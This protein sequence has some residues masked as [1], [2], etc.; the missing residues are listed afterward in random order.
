MLEHSET[1]QSYSNYVEAAVFDVDKLCESIE[2]VK[3]EYRFQIIPIQN[4]SKAPAV[5]KWQAKDI[6][7]DKIGEYFDPDETLRPFQ[8]YGIVIPKNMVVIDVD[9]K[10]GKDGFASQLKLEKDL[11]ISLD[12]STSLIVSSGSG[13]YSKHYFFTLPEDHS[14]VL[15]D[16]LKDAGYPDIDIK[17]HGG[18]VIGA[19]SNYAE[20][21]ANS[22]SKF[23]GNAYSFIQQGEPSEIP[24][25]LLSSITRP[26][27]IKTTLKPN[28]SKSLNSSG[29]KHIAEH[30]L[31][32]ISADC[33]YELWLKVGMALHFET[34]GAQEGYELFDSWSASVGS[35]VGEKETFAKWG[36]FQ[37]APDVPCTLGTI[38][39]YAKKHPDFQHPKC[40]DYRTETTQ[41]NQYIIK[42]LL[43]GKIP[44]SAITHIE[45]FFP[46]MIEDEESEDAVIRTSEQLLKEASPAFID[47]LCQSDYFKHPLVFDG[48]HLVCSQYGT[49]FYLNHKGL[50]AG[51]NALE[52]PYPSTFYSREDTQKKILNVIQEALQQPLPLY[53]SIE[54]SFNFPKLIVLKVTQGSGKTDSTLKA[55]AKLPDNQ[56]VLLVEPTTRKVD[57]AIHDLRETYGKVARPAY[58]PSK[59]NNLCT[60]LEKSDSKILSEN[61]IFDKSLCNSC[62]YMDECE[63]QKRKSINSN[64]IISTTAALVTG[65]ES[66]KNQLGEKPEIDHL[67]IDEDPVSIMIKEHQ[68]DENSISELEQAL[69]GGYS[70]IIKTIRDIYSSFKDNCENK[71]VIDMSASISMI[72][73]IAKD[74]K[75]YCE[76]EQCINDLERARD[77]IKFPEIENLDDDWA[78]KII[79]RNHLSKWYSPLNLLFSYIKT[80]YQEGA[81]SRELQKLSNV[82]VLFMPKVSE[83]GTDCLTISEFREDYLGVAKKPSNILL[84]DAT[85]NQSIIEKAFSNYNYD[86]KVIEIN[87]ARN[88]KTIQQGS[89]KNG[90]RELVKPKQQV[91]AKA[92]N[93]KGGAVI[94]RKSLS[95]TF[96]GSYF[97]SLKGRNT[98]QG[99]NGEEIRFSDCQYFYEFGQFM[100]HGNGIASKASA[101]WAD[102]I[103]H[104]DGSIVD[105]DH[106]LRFETEMVAVPYC[107]PDG[108]P[109]GIGAMRYCYYDSRLH[110]VDI[111]KTD[112]EHIQA[113]RTRSV[114]S[115]KEKALYIDS[116]QPIFGRIV[117]EVYPRDEF[118]KVVANH[119]GIELEKTKP[120]D[121][122]DDKVREL[123]NFLEDGNEIKASMGEI[124]KNLNTT[125]HY[126]K[127]VLSHLKNCEQE[128][129]PLYRL[130]KSRKKGKG[131]KL[132]YSLIN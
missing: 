94:T 21:R 28:Y 130:L 84:L 61:S 76:I 68:I 39:F 96:S 118:K 114:W 6:P 36:S 100:Y 93:D 72:E 110:E 50:L 7:M 77:E 71:P 113:D 108:N 107:M 116:S 63:Y 8:A 13:G 119:L 29:V 78:N 48:T 51:C 132:H 70:S 1:Q 60:K 127:T 30:Y 79:K 22:T 10:I 104:V 126:A 19:G 69:D 85:A 32:Y 65:G 2:F 91:L 45:F 109:K 66:L 23:N 128:G 34:G 117:D 35:Y 120:E 90:K 88:L 49:N 111:S 125:E 41:F 95:S 105:Q 98:F 54:K 52:N 89:Q 12:E 83:D 97:G 62:K 55:M 64:V 59:G 86:I 112:A 121:K 74:R 75:M 47:Q 42:E 106:Q 37:N 14:G 46:E 5:D 33:D 102:K 25:K 15:C 44:S 17:K 129:S 99:G 24:D 40:E 67:I 57:E 9:A 92:I 103:N 73:K 87:V 3:K 115:D 124:K 81:M 131:T 4:D 20:K 31:Q 16:K 27:P 26:D 82:P 11:G 53:D 38:I 122:R 123:L 58:A 80:Q 101:L 56:V 18:Y 43:D